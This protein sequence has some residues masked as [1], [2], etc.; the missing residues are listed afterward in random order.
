MFM[1]EVVTSSYNPEP[2]SRILR[3]FQA[4]PTLLD[5]LPNRGQVARR[6]TKHSGQT[7]VLRKWQIWSL[8]K[9]NLLLIPKGANYQPAA[10][11]MGTMSL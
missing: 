4:H 6:G 7:W 8:T 10:D 1:Q 3:M 11:N 5:D 2:C 9:L